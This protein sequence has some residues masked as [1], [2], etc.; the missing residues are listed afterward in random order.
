MGE[1]GKLHQLI[2]PFFGHDVT[3][4]LEVVVMIRPT[5]VRDPLPDAAL[6]EYPSACELLSSAL[7]ER[8]VA[9]VPEA[10]EV[11]EVVELVAV[12][13]CQSPGCALVELGVVDLPLVG[14]VAL[15]ERDHAPTHTEEAAHLQVLHGLG[16]DP[17]VG[18]HQ[19]EGQ[20][21]AAGAGQDA[22]SY[23]QRCQLP[24]HGC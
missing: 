4:N 6:W 13:G 10:E 16:H 1:L 15:A 5:I 14:Q 17:L 2:I 9:P 7:P 21:H 23:D 19:Q 11:E 8:P 12:D 3:V 24:R 20:V 22:D 18:R